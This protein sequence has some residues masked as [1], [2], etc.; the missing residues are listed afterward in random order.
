[1]SG[2]HEHERAQ[3]RMAA[4]RGEGAQRQG[5]P[6]LTAV[7]RADT[8]VLAFDFGTKKIG[9]AVGDTRARIAHPLATITEHADAARLKAIEALIAEWK[10]QLLIVGQPLH[11]DGSE[12]AM[13]ARAERFARQ[14]EGSFGL[15]VVSIDERYTT[16]VAHADLTAAGVRGVRRA[17]ARDRVAAQLILQSWLDEGGS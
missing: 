10:P 1:M 6:S 16:Q 12:H 3:A 4:S 11:A 8:T 2:T 5:G 13:T 14:L 17:A 9:V 15:P 7:L